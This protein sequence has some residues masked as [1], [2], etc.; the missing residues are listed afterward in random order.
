M[1]TPKNKTYVY[2]WATNLIR[3]YNAWKYIVYFV[4]N[5]LHFLNYQSFNLKYFKAG[6][7]VYLKSQIFIYV[8]S[9][10]EKCSTENA[11]KFSENFAPQKGW[12][13]L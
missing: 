1:L 4:C 8:V 5:L 10:L 2:Q 11:A 12:F 13:C 7:K 9:C 3:K 6:R